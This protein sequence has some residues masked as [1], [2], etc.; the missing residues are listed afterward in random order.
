MNNTGS[1]S[2][3][4]TIGTILFL[5]FAVAIYSF[6]GILSKLASQQDFLSFL[7]ICYFAGIIVVLG[8][9]AILWQ[10][11]LK[12]VDL[13][14]AFLFRS[15]GIVYGLLIAYFIFHEHIS[16]QNIIGCALVMSGLVVI[17]GDR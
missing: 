14:Q 12:K 5:A 16:T 7:Y 2:P 3:K 10:I 13:S 15:L 11:A 6:S 8:I 1:T 17:S 4:V 9:Y